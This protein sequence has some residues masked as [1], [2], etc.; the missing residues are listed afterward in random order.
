[1]SGTKGR[2]NVASTAA[3]AALKSRNVTLQ[4]YLLPVFLVNSNSSIDTAHLYG[5][6]VTFPM[7]HLSTELSWN[8][9]ASQNL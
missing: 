1:M 4:L 3:V 2:Y 5:V 6:D 7:N 9:V 8:G